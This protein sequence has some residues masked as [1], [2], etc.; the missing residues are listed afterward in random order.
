MK[1]RNQRFAAFTLVELLVVIAI[2]GILVALL[3]PAVQQAREA[4]RRA[5]CLNNLKQDGLA[6]ANYESARGELPPGRPGCDASNSLLCRYQPRDE[7]MGASGF[8]YMLPYMEEQALYDQYELDQ[9][10]IWMSEASGV[11]WLTEAKQLAISQRPSSYICP[12]SGTEPSSQRPNYINWTYKPGTGDYALVAGHRGPQC[13]SV[14]AC[15]VKLHNTGMFL[16][17]TRVKV[18]KIRD[19]LSKTFA[20]GET[21][22]GHTIAGSNVWTHT[23]RHSDSIRS[24]ESPLNTPL[25]ITVFVEGENLN[26]TFGSRHSGGA[27]FVFGDAHV[28][29]VPDSIDLEVYQELSTIAGFENNK[30]N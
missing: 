16:Y 23:R 12:S 10:G 3:L 25:E 24:T 28:E 21:I 1:T 14:D 13:C 27:N 7:K 26:G 22:G 9:E 17:K 29:F 30:C 18:R 6:I 19:G 20:I 2:I 11:N 5:Q 15:L 4:A 8:V